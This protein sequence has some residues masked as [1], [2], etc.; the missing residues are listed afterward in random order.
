[1]SS[2]KS[3]SSNARFAVVSFTAASV[4]Y[5]PVAAY[6]GGSA[7]DARAAVQ[8]ALAI[9]GSGASSAGTVNLATTSGSQ[10]GALTAQAK[11]QID[12]NTARRQ[13]LV[14]MQSAARAAA[15]AGASS[16]PNG[17]APGGLEVA[18]GATVGSTLWSGADLPVQKEANGQSK[19]NINQTSAQALL[20]WNTFNIGRETALKFEQAKSDWIVFNKIVD[21]SGDPTRIL[22]SIEAPGQVYVINPN[23][24]IFGGGSQV[25]TRTLVASSLPINDGLVSRG[26]LNNPDTQFLFSA[27]A[28]PAGAESAAFIPPASARVDGHYGDVL[29]EAGAILNSPTNAD[30]SGGRVALIGANVTNAGTISTP[31]GQAILAAGLQ[32]GMEG[33][34]DASLRG[35]NV[36]VGKVG[37]YAGTATNAGIID[38]PRGAVTA[39]GRTLEQNGLIG[40]TTSVSRNGRIDL[41]AQYDAI[42][43]GNYASLPDFFATTTGLVSFGAN[44]V[45]EVLPEWGS[46]E[47]VVGTRLTLGSQ[48]NARGLVVHM[49]EDAS[50]CAPS[51]E[52]S[53]SAGRW[54]L[55]QLGTD[56]AN[57][58]F[59]YPEGQV[60]FDRG[61]NVNVAG[62]TG[63]IAS[64]ADNIVEASL[65]GDELANSPLQRD[66]ALRGETI[67]VDILQTG[68][69]NGKTWVGT[70]LADVT[71]YI[72]LVQR[73]VG[74]L[75]TA[76][77]T[78]KINAGGSVVLNP[79]ASIDVSGGFVDY[80]SALVNTTKVLYQGNII[81]IAKATPDLVYDGIYD[82]LFTRETNTSKWG[83]DAA[84]TLQS[85][86]LLFTQEMVAGYTQGGDAGSLIIGAP[87]MALD[88]TLTGQSVS[89]VRQRVTP[90]KSGA[91]TINLQGQYAD[92]RVPGG[93]FT[94][95]RFAPELHIAH[96]EALPAA[97][98]FQL[99]ADGVPAPLKA[100]RVVSLVLSPDLITRSGFSRLTVDNREGDILVDS[101]GV[102]ALPAS[103]ELS[104]SGKN[105]NVG[106]NI[107]APGGKITLAATAV[108]QGSINEAS[109]TGSA[110]ASS[111]NRGSVSVAGGVHLSAAGVLENEVVGTAEDAMVVGG[112]SVSITGYNVSLNPGAVMDVSGGVYAASGNKY[113]YGNA[114]SI[115]IFSGQDANI[116][117][118][119]GGNLVLEETSLLGYSGIKGGKLTLL[120][121]AIQVGGSAASATTTILGTDF[122]N[123]G[124]FTAYDIRGL[125]GVV[126]AA[127]EIYAPGVVVKAGTVIAPVSES[128]FA[129]IDDLAP[130][131]IV[132]TTA[133]L[134]ASLRPATSVSFTAPGVRDPYNSGNSLVVRGGVVVEPN[135]LIQTDPGAKITLAGDT[136]EV[137][138]ALIAK[139][140]A[141]SVKGASNSNNVF[142]FTNNNQAVG[143]LILGSGAFLDASGTTIIQRDTSDRDLRLGRVLSGG[144][145]SL[146]GN[147]QAAVGS[148]IDVSGTTAILDLD[149]VYSG[150]INRNGLDL[151]AT[152]VDSSAGTVTLAGAQQLVTAATL[153]GNAGGAS[154]EGGKLVVSSGIYVPI[155]GS[156]LTQRD[157]NLV[158]T[159]STAA[160]PD[161]SR[162]NFSADSFNNSGF[163]SITLA[164]TVRF[165][166]PVSLNASRQIAVGGN[167]VIFG[168]DSISLVAPRVSIGTPLQ[169]PRL[170]DLDDTRAFYDLN[171]MPYSLPPV[172]GEASLTVNANRLIEVGNLTLQGFGELQLNSD[173][174]DLR[175]SGT[176]DI[177]GD[178]SLKAAQIYPPTATVFNINAYDFETQG[179]FHAGSIKVEKGA[180]AGTLPYSAGGT[181]NL[182][183]SAI[184]QNGTLR[185]PF[186]AVNLGWNGVGLAPIDQVTGLPVPVSLSVSLGANSVT[187]V[188]AVDPATGKGLILPY[189]AFVNGSSW[190]DP[191]GRDITDFGPPAKQV[192]LSAVSVNSEAGS[193]VDV[194]GGGEIVSSRFKT[195]TGGK[196]DVLADLT[197]FTILP[198]YKSDF[199]PFAAFNDSDKG[200]QLLGNEIGYIN[201]NLKPGD[202]IYLDSGAGLAAGFYTLLPARYAV[203]PGAFLVTPKSSAPLASAAIQPDQSVYVSG[204]RFNDA[205]GAPESAP[206]RSLF[207]IAASSVIQKRATYDTPSASVFFRDNA[208]QRGVTIPRLAADAGQLIFTATEYMALDGNILAQAAGSGL[209]GRVD[210]DSPVDIRIAGSG[211]IPVEGEL[212]LDAGKLSAFSGAS[213]L[214]GGVR[215][216]TSEGTQVIVGANSL[217]VDNAGAALGGAELILVA[218]ETL[219]IDSGAKIEQH[220]TI[221]GASDSLV[222]GDSLS[223]SGDGVLLRVSSD[224]SA[225]VK[226]LSVKSESSALLTIAADTTIQGGA[227]LIFDSTGSTL[228]DSAAIFGAE[229]ITLNSGR[230]SLQLAD[231]GEL[232]PNPGLVLSSATMR[233]LQ[234]SSTQLSLLS[235]SSIDLYGTGQVG[236]ASFDQLTIGAPAIRGFNNDGGSVA[237]LA[238][239]I[240]LNGGV[241]GNAVSGGA[242][243]GSISFNANNIKLG[244]GHLAINQYDQ[245]SLRA[246]DKLIF[247]GA[248]G[249]ETEGNIDIATPF[250]T[251]ET[252][253][254]QEITSGGYLNITTPEQAGASSIASGGL[255]AR[256]SLTANSINV[257]STITLASGYLSLNSTGGDLRVGENSFARLDVGGTSRSIQGAV[258]TTN[259]GQLILNA[260][261]GD[262]VLGDR[263][264][265]NVSA[266]SG[267]GDAG[268]IKVSAPS[269]IFEVKGA[270]LGASGAKGQSGG[271][272]ADIG[273]FTGSSLGS[274]DGVLNAGGFELFRS[275]RIRSGNVKFEGQVSASS[276]EVSVDDGAL[277]IAGVIDA[278]GQTGG[279]IKLS[280]HGNLTILSQARLDVS[281]DEFNSA[282]KGGSIRLEAGASRDGLV[283]SSAFLTLQSGSTL[284]L[285]V[286]ASRSDLDVGLGHS[287]GVLYLR[288]PRDAAGTDLAIKP[289]QAAIVG[290]SSVVAEGFKVHDLTPVTGTGVT[291]TTAE[292]NNALADATIFGDASPSV[293][294]RIAGGVDPN[295]FHIQPSLE[296]INRAGD[297]ALDG[298]W[299]LSTARYGTASDYVNREPG[300]LTIRAAG[301]I[302]LPYVAAGSA[303]LS[304]GFGDGISSAET[305]QKLWNAPLLAAG[306]RSWSFNLVAGADLAASRTSVVLP[307]DA[308]SPGAGSILFGD[309]ATEYATTIGARH[310]LFAV[311]QYFQVIRTGTG[312]I[313]IAARTDIE[314]RNNLG[315][316]YTS[317]T[318]SAAMANF[319]VPNTGY[320][321]AP[322]ELG[323]RQYASEAYAA[324]YSQLGGDVSLSAQRDIFRTFVGEIDS[325]KQM[326]TNWLYR[327]G[328][329]DE[330]TGEFSAYTNTSANGPRTQRN[331]TSWWVDFNNFFEG[332]GTLG[333][334]DIILSAGNDI[335]NIDAV[336]PTNA[337]MPYGIPDSGKLLELGGGGVSVRAGGN[338]DGGVYYVER[339]AAE[340]IAGSAIMT[341][342]TRSTL[343][344][345]D[346]ISAAD[347]PAASWLPTT[348]FLGKGSFSLVAGGDLSV[349]SVVNPFLLPAGINNSYFLKSYFST[350]SA[351]SA[352]SAASLT[353][354]VTV[355]SR[356]LGASTGS[357]FD[358]YNNVLRRDAVTPN[359]TASGRNQPWLRLYEKDVAG[360]AVAS[361]LMPGSAVVS[362]AEGDI[363]L[364]GEFNFIPSAAGELKLIAAGSLN[365]LNVVATNASSGLRQWASAVL[366]FSDA[367][368]SRLPDSAS[369]VSL[370]ARGIANTN[371]VNLVSRN[372]PDLA[373]FDSLFA[374]SGSYTGDIY[375]RLQTKQ[376]LHAAR[377]VHTG[378]VEPVQLFAGSGDISGLTLYSAQF[379][380]VFAGRDISD[381]GLYFQN[382]NESDMSIVS[383]GRD[384]LLY[385]SGSVGRILAQT[386]GNALLGTS[387]RYPG[388]G[389]GNPNSGDLQI[390][391]SGTLLVQAGRN[392]DFGATLPP[393]DGASGGLKSPGDGTA[394]GLSSIGNVRNLSLPEAG[395]DVVI[396]VGLGDGSAINRQA[397][398]AQFLNPA[399]AGANAARYLPVLAEQLGVSA[400]NHDAI[401]AAYSALSQT[402]RDPLTLTAFNRVLRDAGR[403]HGNADSPGF[404]NYQAG[405]DAI[406]ALFPESSWD[407]DL[408]ISSRELRTSAGGDVVVYAPGGGV[409]LGSEISKS[410]T[411]P[412]IITERGGAISIFTHDDVDIG[413]Q[414]IFTLRGGDVLIWSTV[415]DIAAG[416]SSTT[417]QSASPTRVL[418]DP[419]TGD[420][421][422]DLAGL[423]TGGGIGV[424]AAVEGVKAGDVDLIAPVGTIDAGD[425]G[426]R[427]AGNINISALTVLNAANISSGGV[428]SGAPTVVAPNIAGLSV[429]STASAAASATASSANQTAGNQSAPVAL[430]SFIT[431][432]VMGYG[433]GESKK[434]DQ[435]RDPAGG[436]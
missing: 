307:M 255:G 64:V 46:K 40:A 275:Y 347:T 135:A 178:I 313:S 328:N 392:V 332:V 393:D 23:G 161:M 67:R 210:I 424:L 137:Q 377:S 188:S 423:A 209:G 126:D 140:G 273:S 99:G 138:G 417:I 373:A 400:T 295:I 299:D 154:A 278:S 309:G 224:S 263:G 105:I 232:Q 321:V 9:Q 357:V 117:S 133:L 5:A 331:S 80:Q 111:P 201:S 221:G 211:A 155:V 427:S 148:V 200:R 371:V 397:F 20:T 356:N 157:V 359:A 284:D 56:Q 77:G 110:P 61:A 12:Q 402:D 251:S 196:A 293:L 11:A 389:T 128:Y 144:S 346:Y 93:Y 391:G 256:L 358:W 329:L 395:A 239:K 34:P 220:G 380:E 242:S 145:V 354:D 264:A 375:G 75:T 260:M 222:I 342:Y 65:R 213:L 399:S 118:V 386:E 339:G 336:A 7:A 207:E 338:I 195:G 47:K 107:T 364:V 227:G 113:S 261:G 314:F 95:S 246:A 281:A 223:G 265:L 49:G 100:E 212:L 115:A 268:A 204:Y 84:K 343:R 433:G 241:G 337:R 27:L 387:L 324:Q 230:I 403:D 330:A 79:N 266:V 225:T 89:G 286:N 435:D 352:F 6:A 171:S 294:S 116:K 291:I 404:G 174:G 237:F 136:V 340:L 419:Q 409:N 280:A 191:Q 165:S 175:G 270:V 198:D 41:L 170:A 60:Y 54:N 74:Q 434:E 231:S 151:V 208:A 73:D 158:V 30:K 374:E 436:A 85:A 365:G 122:F 325:S 45:T 66:G 415:G 192:V 385:N 159:Q 8:R 271:F 311:P 193:I 326:P 253:S 63:V 53:L 109:I 296:F 70:P 247:N 168:D 388:P 312:D 412:G 228:I 18:T 317:G 39:A 102:L 250:I 36:S 218:K 71:G 147:I 123:T 98:T 405:Y 129:S 14:A 420:V 162:G 376:N 351:D 259:G 362:A 142:P 287:A 272:T 55:L 48:I 194:N 292:R 262:V 410:Q 258:I 26:L 150:G 119:V 59:V 216:T 31:D 305:T 350:Y 418:V 318:Q 185:A 94:D 238:D 180:L 19:V 167:G 320:N 378:A 398:E 304:D 127:S 379:A 37:D 120:A 361:T 1:M 91:L 114:G 283:E 197:S 382:L 349:G 411:P 164:G 176:V 333:G 131:K 430:P 44:S 81:D 29:V 166:G 353:G 87:S 42:G 130:E 172:H 416:S 33:S 52:V 306:S 214:I 143:T 88:A 432:E 421:K 303:S 190:V 187:S 368:P 13:S 32:V 249:L 215:K 10:A 301:N 252:A 315:T 146:S 233:G 276:Y 141:I 372:S 426:I 248:G 285:S 101:S 383:A 68:T 15:L 414:R 183:A 202:R 236:S 244:A 50:I 199:A 302:V 78:V 406:A 355:R 97:D 298:I 240:A 341:N 4:F 234:E 217:T 344:V 149:P 390:G 297:I 121:P 422:T 366:N 134:E 206:L 152:E 22:G 323:A 203:L 348:L 289:I 279:V 86:N 327:R 25:N 282:G 322:T 62:T 106:A 104:L 181:L 186:G 401:W 108:S 381:V 156:A 345:S 335:A 407:G 51:A 290:A 310:D 431:L 139:G 21:P 76:G 413:T 269:G 153:R 316:I 69:Y 103:G 384:I 112:G 408:R 288:A 82:G 308:A 125:G 160:T 173:A 334:G 219:S 24:I 182:H 35:L 363:N 169:K 58:Q 257:D 428:T 72:N 132:F 184:R 319:D 3:S 2:S 43:V 425:A 429:A 370:S 226:R 205:D 16:V 394:V 245:V 267:G 177:A 229:S 57:A 235:Y 17:L 179:I 254:T 367:D 274:M 277:D 300:V 28:I 369:P 96:Q 243:A 124:G 92:S 38:S 163:D 189:G 396:G 360:F 90:A 83:G